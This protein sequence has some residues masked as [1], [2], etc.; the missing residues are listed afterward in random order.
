MMEVARAERATADMKVARQNAEV[1]GPGV[2]VGGVTDA[3][4][5]FAEEDRV[6]MVGLHGEKLDPGDLNGQLLPAGGV[7]PW[8]ETQ[9]IR[10]AGRQWSLAG[11]G[12]RL[13]RLTALQH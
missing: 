11:G 4:F 6:A 3:G 8:Q 9:A 2:D 12:P 1:L 7:V 5:E 10:D 13:L